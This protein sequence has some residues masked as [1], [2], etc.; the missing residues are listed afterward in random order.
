MIIFLRRDFLR[1]T[2]TQ[3]LK[4]FENLYRSYDL[5]WDQ[6]SF[7]RLVFWIC[8]RAEVIGAEQISIDSLSKEN[9]IDRLEKLW[10]KR[11]GT[12]N[13]KEAYT[14]S[15][16]FAALTDFNG[17]LQARDIVRFLYHAA[18]ITVD[19]AKEI[20][21]ER[22]STSRL[23]PPQAMRRALKPCSEEKVKEAQEEYA[24]FKIWVEE[25]LP[26]Y[27]PAERRIPFAGEQFGI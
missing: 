7:L 23:L 26:K 14:A 3:N 15:W 5:S 1:Y 27:P 19:R 25:T 6:D 13:S 4:Q 11:L 21:F 17:R 9:F 8:S 12:D 10:G 18:K 2:I 16:V 24:V 20:Q 22:W